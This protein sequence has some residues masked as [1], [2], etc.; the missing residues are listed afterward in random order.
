MPKEVPSF[1]GILGV[2]MPYRQ[3]WNQTP[4]TLSE[5]RSLVVRFTRV[6]K[7]GKF[8]E[9]LA[10]RMAGGFVRRFWVSQ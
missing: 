8:S 3:R 7:K 9:R 5:L 4:G 6:G 2:G 1:L 10:F